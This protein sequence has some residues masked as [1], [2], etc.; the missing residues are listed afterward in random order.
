MHAQIWTSQSICNPEIFSCAYFDLPN[1]L[2]LIKFERTQ[3]PFCREVSLPSSLSS[4]LKV[5]NINFN[6]WI[7]RSNVLLAQ[8]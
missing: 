5:P 7:P 6:K 8:S 4:L 3:I 2:T 1:K